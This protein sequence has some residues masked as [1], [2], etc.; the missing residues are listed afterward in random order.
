[1]A[2]QSQMTARP[3]LRA[4]E[5][6]TSEMQHCFKVLMWLHPAK[7]RERSFPWR[8]VFSRA[9]TPSQS[10]LTGLLTIG[11]EEKNLA[12]LAIHSQQSEKRSG[13]F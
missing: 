7:W 13:T 10:F 9:K 5:S 6:R 8:E 12:I 11:V 1:M 4:V 3:K 2:H